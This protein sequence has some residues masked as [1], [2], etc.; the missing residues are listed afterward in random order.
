MKPIDL[1]GFE[2]KFVGDGDP[3]QTFTNRDEAR[4]RQAIVHAMGGAISGRVLELAA[5][6][7]S[8]SAAL[9]RRALRLDATEGTE[10]GTQLVTQAIADIPRARASLLVLPSAFPRSRY[11]AIVVAEVLYYLTPAAMRS[12]ARRVANAMRQGGRLV[13]AHHRVDYPDF[14]QHAG[15]IHRRFLS[16]SGATWNMRSVVRTGRWIVETGIRG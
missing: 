13:V 8:N 4:K 15:E 14:V 3:W 10:A 7:G 2:D 5:G 11:E 1:A 12:T 6:N 9:A 16:A